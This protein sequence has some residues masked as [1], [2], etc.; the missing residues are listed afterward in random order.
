MPDEPLGMEVKGIPKVLT[1]LLCCLFLFRAATAQ[2]WKKEEITSAYIFNFA[3][4]I[5]WQNEDRIP[6]FR[7]LIISDD[8][9]INREMLNLSATRKLKGKPISVAISQSVVIPKD[10]QLI[11]I[12]RGMKDLT[13]PVFRR[14]E[15]RKTL[16]IT[17][18]FEDKRS[19]MINLIET[20]DKTI[21]FEINKAN[22]INQGLKVL[23]EMVLLGGTEI[24]VAKLYKEAQD[25]LRIKEGDIE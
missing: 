19:V 1:A 17:E 20:K 23:P 7:F 4:N 9:A 22:I 21:K 6:E 16:L 11:F 15:G 18:G 12:T 10:I 5:E 8:G 2:Q 14:I 24:D 25:T 13:D 3:K